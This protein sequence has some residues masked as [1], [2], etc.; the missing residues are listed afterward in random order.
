MCY[1]CAGSWPRFF[2]WAEPFCHSD[3]GMLASMCGC[4]PSHVPLPAVNSP[5]NSTSFSFSR[6]LQSSL[7][8]WQHLF[9][10]PGK[11]L[12]CLLLPSTKA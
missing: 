2:R 8:M 4:P 5:M 3:F 6:G 9:R 10:L 1:C 12:K 7:E 11:I